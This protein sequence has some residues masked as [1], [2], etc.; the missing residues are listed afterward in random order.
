LACDSP[1]N[2]SLRFCSVFVPFSF[3]MVSRDNSEL[4]ADRAAARS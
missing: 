4:A 1:A 3:M 2:A